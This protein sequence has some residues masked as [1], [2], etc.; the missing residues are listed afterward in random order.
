LDLGV[1]DGSRLGVPGTSLTGLSGPAKGLFVAA[2]V[3]RAR[4][5]LVVAANA[6]EQQQKAARRFMKRR[7]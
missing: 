4:A 3:A 1:A 7:C 2:T 5:L 6:S